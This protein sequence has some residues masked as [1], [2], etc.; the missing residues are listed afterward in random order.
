MKHADVCPCQKCRGCSVPIWPS[1]SAN[2]LL[3]GMQILFSQ[4]N[5]SHDQVLHENTY[6][7]PLRVPENEGRPPFSFCNATSGRVETAPYSKDTVLHVNWVPYRLQDN[8]NT[9]WG[10]DSDIYFQDVAPAEQYNRYQDWLDVNARD[11]ST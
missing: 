7:L 4:D 1:N 5:H 2:E 6:N 9:P 3:Y 10:S 8:L 11:K